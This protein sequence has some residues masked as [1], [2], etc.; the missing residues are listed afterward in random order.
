MTELI[1]IIVGGSFMYAGVSSLRK[2]KK[3]MK[4]GIK[5]KATI[6]EQVREKVNKDGEYYY[7]PIVKFIDNQGK[8]ITQKLGNGTGAKL[9]KTSIEIAYIRTPEGLEIE[10]VEGG[11]KSFYQILI[12]FGL[13][14]I[15]FAIALLLKQW[16]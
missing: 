12:G 14:F 4:A 9:S 8:E 10:I 15:V 2:N 11:W 3:V 7:F 13:L 6:L 1:F 5:T 16:L